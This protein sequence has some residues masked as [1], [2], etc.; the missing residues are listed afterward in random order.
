[1]LKHKKRYEES[2]RRS[3]EW[4]L[5]QV[6]EDGTVNP[7]EKG[8]IAYYKLPWALIMGG[9]THKAKKIIDW[10]VKETLAADGD[11]KSE[12]RQKFHLDYYTYPNAWIC[13]ASHLLSL[14]DISYPMWDY[15]ATHQD[16]ATGGYC[17][18]APYKS[19]EDNLQDAI[20][21]A[22][23]SVVGLHLGKLDQAKRAAGFLKNLLDIQPNFEEEFFYYWYPNK[24]LVLEKPPE[25][26]DLRFIRINMN[27]RKENFYYI[28]GAVVAF[29]SKLALTTKDKD[30]LN[31]ARAYYG[32]IERAGEHPLHTESCGK[33]CYA[34]THLYHASGDAKYLEMAEIFMNS[35]LEIGESNGSWIRGGKPTAS[36]TAEFCVWRYNLLFIGD[37][38]VRS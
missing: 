18:R 7:A 13:I 35:L 31:L 23:N 36:S 15:I 19:G 34:S 38:H 27:D 9:E 33:L 37:A 16:P 11:L 30:T 25:E 2:V 5:T 10:T 32:F 1:M 6:N 17:S 20:S 8:S 26:P 4:L 24:G 21:T 28:L 12:K 3:I 14:F 29:L 22:W